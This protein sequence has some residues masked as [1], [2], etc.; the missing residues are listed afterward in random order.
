MS[1]VKV[2]NVPSIGISFSAAV[3][4]GRSL[5]FQTHAPQDVADEV[6]NA[7][8]DKVYNAAERVVNRCAANSLSFVIEKMEDD[9]QARDKEMKE[10]TAP[11]PD[12]ERQLEEIAGGRREGGAAKMLAAKISAL[13]EEQKAHQQ[14]SLSHQYQV[15]KMKEKQA[16]HLALVKE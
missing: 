15:A 10:K 1:E 12:L 7:L 5:V 14:N 16:N 4:E 3:S 9:F 8:V 11:L 2:E 13:R 6:L